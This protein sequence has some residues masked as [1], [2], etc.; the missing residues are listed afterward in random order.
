MKIVRENLH[1]KKTI[2]LKFDQN[3][4]GRIHSNMMVS[5]TNPFSSVLKYSALMY[6]VGHDK[7]IETSIVPIRAELTGIEMWNDVIISLVLKDWTLEE[8]K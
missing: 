5:V 8:G 2:I 3:M 4:E 1:P 7:W 6:L